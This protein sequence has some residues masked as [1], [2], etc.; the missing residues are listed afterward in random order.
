M[1]Q[2]RLS[3]VCCQKYKRQ[4][5]IPSLLTLDSEDEKKARKT[6]KSPKDAAAPLE[7]KHPVTYVS[8]SG[9]RHDKQ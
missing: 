9:E 4:Y 3:H 8:D 5:K 7:K 1:N 6:K 2:R